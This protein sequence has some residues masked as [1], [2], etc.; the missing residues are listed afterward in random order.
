MAIRLQEAGIPYVILEKN[1]E[2]GGTWLDNHYPDCGVDT[3]C[4]FFSYSFE[5]NP[6]WTHF[7]AKRDEI[8]GY[9][10]HCAKKYDVRRNIR[11]Q[12]EVL[13]AEYRP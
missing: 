13:A 7:F 11:F 6:D 10:L 8:L 5:P 4:H 1:A 3:P 2:V 12:E 9:I